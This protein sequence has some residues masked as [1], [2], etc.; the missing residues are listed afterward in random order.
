MLFLLITFLLVLVYQL[1]FL[2]L[3][4]SSIREKEGKPEDCPPV[5]VLLY[6]DDCSDT[7]PEMLRALSDQNYPAFEVIVVNNDR[8]KDTEA[9]LN[10]FAAEHRNFYHT[11]IPRDARYLSRKKLA[12]TLAVKAAHYD[13]F[14]LLETDCLPTSRH[15]IHAMMQSYREQTEIVLGYCVYPFNNG[16]T[17]KLIAYANLTDGMSYLSSALASRFYRGNGRNLSY[18]RAIFEK[19]QG[20]RRHLNLVAGDDDLFVHEAARE[21]NTAVS[22]APDS[23]TRRREP[24]TRAAWRQENLT[25]AV[26]AQHVRGVLPVLLRLEP[27]VCSV[28]WVTA[29]YG[30]AHLVQ[31]WKLPVLAFVLFSVYY[32]IKAWIYRRASAL[33][34]TPLNPFLLPLL[35]VLNMAEHITLLLHYPF[36][37]RSNYIFWVDRRK[38]ERK[39]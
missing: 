27:F 1:R 16:I 21:G 6:A 15:W 30:I 39:E 35:D 25:H 26:S 12:L 5:S 8:D 34:R 7:L 2:R 17:Q 4:T 36:A 19:A 29:I 24:L 14:L 13:H 11:Y 3:V 32:G 38:K 37:K 23:F 10:H 31:D 22:L 9:L 28:F 18:T 20:F 33:F